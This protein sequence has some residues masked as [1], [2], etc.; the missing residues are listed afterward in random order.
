VPTRDRRSLPLQVRDEIRDLIERDGLRTGDQLPTEAELA[1]RFDVARTTVREALKLLEQDGLIGVR[2]GR[3]RFVLAVPGVQTPITRLE[4]VTEMM[5]RLGYRVTN[6]VLSVDE[7]TATEEESTALA[8]EPGAAVI[9]LERLRLQVDEPLIYSID[10]IPRSVVEGALATVDWSGSL[11]ELLR[12]R[13]ITFVSATAQIRAANLPR[14]TERRLGVEAGAPWL[15]AEMVS[16]TETGQPVIYSHDWHR[17]DLFT[18]H[19]L[20]R[21]AE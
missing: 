11:Q 14:A 3:G 12:A 16:Y 20:R 2:H 7:G 6:R 4:S 21:R 18:F 1:L 8:L 9:R 15:L 13:G 10:V 5:E 17:G 19:V